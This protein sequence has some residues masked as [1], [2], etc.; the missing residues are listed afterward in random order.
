MSETADC[1]TRCCEEAS[2]FWIGD[3]GGARDRSRPS[4]LVLWAVALAALFLIGGSAWLLTR[5]N[6]RPNPIHGTGGQKN[7]R[8]TVI[9]ARSDVTAV[10]TLDGTLV[11]TPKFA[12]LSSRNSRLS[13]L[14]NG[15]SGENIKAGRTLFSQGEVSVRTPVAGSFV[16]W[17]VPNGAQ[18]A[19]GIPV[20]EIAYGGF[21]V[22]ANLPPEAA[23][24]LYS[25]HIVARAEI[26]NGPGPFDCTMLISPA[27]PSIPDAH[28]VE[29]GSVVSAQP[30]SALYQ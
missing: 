25:N 2:K 5:S 20:A 29:S 26:L 8:S 14:W 22:A 19:A 13:Y 18:V 1:K 24:R 12:V 15:R 23:Y 27:A 30:S 7:G 10:L 16:R 6:G 4:R 21:G 28:G 11:A 17:L 3:P 9:V